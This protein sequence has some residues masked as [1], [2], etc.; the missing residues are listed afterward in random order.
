MPSGGLSVP[1]PP[2]VRRRAET[3]SEIQPSA[4]TLSLSPMPTALAAALTGQKQ[5]HFLAKASMSFCNA[6]RN[7]TPRIAPRHSPMP[8]SVD[9]PFAAFS[10][11]AAGARPADAGAHTLIQLAASTAMRSRARTISAAR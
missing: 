1:A 2:A 10:F 11:A 5:T 3:H 7:P 9:T 4:T 6:V 8:I